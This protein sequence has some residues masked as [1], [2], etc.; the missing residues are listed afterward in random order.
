MNIKHI[1]CDLAMLYINTHTHIEKNEVLN[2]FR[3]LWCLRLESSE[4]YVCL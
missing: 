2:L 4:L 3:P 1:L